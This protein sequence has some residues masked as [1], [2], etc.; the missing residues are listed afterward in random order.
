MSS[1]TLGTSSIALLL[2]ALEGPTPILSA[3]ALER[4]PEEA[5]VL[6]ASLLI[7][8]HGHE[9]VIATAHSD[10]P[11]GLTWAGDGGGY[12]YFSETDGW[13]SVSSEQIERYAVDIVAFITALTAKLRLAPRAPP[14]MRV[15]HHLWDLGSARFGRRAKRTPVL[16]GR[17]LHN[18]DVWK[19]IEQVFR[20][21]PALERRILLT[22]TGPSLLPKPPPK[23]VIITISDLVGMSGDLAI[24]PETV[25]ACLNGVPLLDRDEPLMVLG[26]GKEVR[27]R[28]KI[29]RFARGAKQ[30][31]VI[32]LLHRRYLEGI[33]WVSS[34]EIAEELELG[35]TRVRD[36]FKRNPAWNQLLTERG[37]MCGFCFEAASQR[38]KAA[39]RHR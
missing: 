14:R 12:G 30:R 7:Q 24:D 31:E 28:G 35:D 11:V 39:K 1:S 33:I 20:R 17:R 32:R 8:P 36:L 23:C 38:A 26:D 16:F 5:A 3:A 25:S 6:K 37:G 18:A 10:L 9:A 29:F 22:S 2:A 19:E 13:V 27:L 21:Q 4:F 34:D 15:D